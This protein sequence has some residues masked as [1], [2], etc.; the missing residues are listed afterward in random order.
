MVLLLSNISITGNPLWDYLITQT[1]LLSL[2][3]YF[4]WVWWKRSTKEIDGLKDE[5]KEKNQY[6]QAN[7]KEMIKTLTKMTTILEN[8]GGKMDGVQIV[9]LKEIGT[10]TN[11]LKTHLELM[12]QK[13]KQNEKDG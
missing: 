10:S 5:L 1:P 2:T 9:I 8:M 4:F 11:A 3:L 13:I 12:L 7:D 6:I